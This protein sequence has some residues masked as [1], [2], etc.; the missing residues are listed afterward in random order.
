MPI[1]TRNTNRGFPLPR[2]EER[3]G[4]VVR[5]QQ[6]RQSATSHCGRFMSQPQNAVRGSR[7]VCQI[8]SQ[9]PHRLPDPSDRL[10][11]FCKGILALPGPRRAKLPT[12]RA[13]SH[14][15]GTQAV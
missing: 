15:P 8:Q 2:R 7:Q 11:G 14:L 5:G 3:T 6:W 10:R 13:L 9:T 1:G 4:A 12:V